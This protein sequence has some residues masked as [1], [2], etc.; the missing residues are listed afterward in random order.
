MGALLRGRRLRGLLAAGVCALSVPGIALAERPQVELLWPGGA[1][2]SAGK[3]GTET[4]RINEHGEHIVS[5]VNVPTL[6][7]YLPA[8]GKAPGAAVIVLPGGGHTELW[9]DH[10]GKNIAQYLSRRGVSAYIL[11]YR[12][13]HAPGSTYT[14]EGD[15]LADVQRAIRLV[16]SRAAEWRLDPDRIGVLGFS[17]GGQLAALAA[18]APV[19]SGATSSADPIERVSSRP[20]F[21]A[22]LYPAIPRGLTLSPTMP[23]AFLACGADDQSTNSSGLAELYLALKRAG[24]RAELHIYDGV[25]HG[26]GI[27]P[28]MTGPVAEW[29]RQFLTWLDQQGRAGR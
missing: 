27:R 15:E 28:G 29:P 1:P 5:N 2:G 9:M 18:A 23:P 14:V 8:R 4:V 13:A 16:R 19:D 22:L 17:A 26:F 10:E 12:L 20:S 25:G 21:E 6:T 11:K 7:V 24:A 3:T